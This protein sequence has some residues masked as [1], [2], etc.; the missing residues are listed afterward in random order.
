MSSDEANLNVNVEGLTVTPKMAPSDTVVSSGGAG[1]T[2]EQP[3]AAQKLDGGGM[4]RHR[5]GAGSPSPQSS[6]STPRELTPAP[7]TPEG[8]TL[9]GENMAIDSNENGVD[10]N[11]DGVDGDDEGSVSD[12]VT[13]QEEVFADADEEEATRNRNSDDMDVDSDRFPPPSS[14]MDVQPS[15]R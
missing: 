4:E 6:T 10:S 3:S 15:I 5:I 11:E 1:G 13:N 14:S 12:V 2:G 7:E 9:S 8:G